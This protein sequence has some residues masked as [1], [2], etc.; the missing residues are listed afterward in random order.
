[1]VVFFFKFMRLAAWLLLVL[2]LLQLPVMF[3]N[4]NGHGM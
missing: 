1:V 3:S 4:Y 2:F